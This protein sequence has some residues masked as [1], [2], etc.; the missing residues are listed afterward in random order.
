VKRLLINKYVSMGQTVLELAC[1]HGQD[2]WKYADRCI[3]K[4]VGVDVSVA[5]IRE[6]RRRVREGQAA[7]HLLQQMLHPPAFHVG[8]LVDRRALSFLR[9]EQFD[10]VSIQLAIHYMVQTEQQARE[11]LG[12]AAAHLKEGGM[13]LGSTVCCGALADHLI[14]LA[15]VSEAEEPPETLGADAGQGAGEGEKAIEKCDF[16]NE[17]YSVTFDLD[18]VD[19]L[20]QGAPG[21]DQ[22]WM[23]ARKEKIKAAAGSDPS[24]WKQYL[25]ADLPVEARAAVGEHLRKRLETEF[26]VEYHFFLSDAI[27]AKEF[28]LPWRSFCAVAASLGLKLMLSMTFPEFLAAAAADPVSERGLKRW[29]ERLNATSR[30]DKPQFEAFSLYKVFVFKK[31][32]ASAEKAGAALHRASQGS[33][34]SAP[35]SQLSPLG[36]PSS[37][38]PQVSQPSADLDAQLS[39]DVQSEKRL[40]SGRQAEQAGVYVHPSAQLA[41]PARGG[42]QVTLDGSFPADRNALLAGVPLK[43]KKTKRAQNLNEDL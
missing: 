34:A 7:R 30:L 3:G 24:A 17:V 5:E 1:G 15:F 20:L 16:G 35:S 27:D 33:T 36:V 12:R 22:N 39:G 38:E 13:V 11:V 10:V 28:V 37:T 43:R 9:S 32:T 31:A 18:T 2:M 23:A 40:G 26:G 25:F 8:N 6:A 19:K 4:F 29:L 41:G 42:E 21:I 14:E